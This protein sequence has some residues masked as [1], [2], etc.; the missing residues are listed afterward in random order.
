M[1]TLHHVPQ[2]RSMRVLWLL[3][4]LGVSFELR[5]YPFDKTL[6]RPDFL[7]LS[8]AG[9]VPAL[10][11]EGVAMFESGAI[12]QYLC[13]RFSPEGLGRGPD[14]AER[15]DWLVWL[16][17]AETLSQHTATTLC[18]REALEAEFRRIRR[19]GYAVDAE[20]FVEGLVCVAVPVPG[21]DG[22]PRSAVALQAPA[23]RMSLAQALE[24]LP[25]LQEAAQALARS[26]A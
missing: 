9:R 26:W 15:R 11:I 16:S 18:T 14:S 13:E 8:P 3:N 17:F 19:D 2:T 10:E 5:T 22:Q 21:S 25:R 24:K 23:A 20:E 6:R 7:G 1:I 12:L 4:E